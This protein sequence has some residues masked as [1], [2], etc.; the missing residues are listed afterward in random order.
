MPLDLEAKHDD[1]MQQ[2]GWLLEGAGPAFLPKLTV[3]CALAKQTDAD[4][5]CEQYDAL[6]ADYLVL[7]APEFHAVMS[8][9]SGTFLEFSWSDRDEYDVF[10]SPS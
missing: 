6:R 4:T 5:T 1:P 9:L 3:A 10:V 2:G 7:G 8:S